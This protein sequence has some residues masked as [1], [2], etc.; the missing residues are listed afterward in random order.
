MKKNFKLTLEYDG[1][2]YSGWQ[3]QNKSR[4][5]QGE[6]ENALSLMLD[7]PIRICGSGRTDAG[8]HALAQVASFHACTSMGQSQLKKGLKIGRAHV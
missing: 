5:I 1:T 2:A 8:V 7:Q 3:V 4:T 6:I